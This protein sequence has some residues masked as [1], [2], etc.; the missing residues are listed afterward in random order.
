MPWRK[1]LLIFGLTLSGCQH[2]PAVKRD[3]IHVVP[4]VIYHEGENLI[5]YTSSDHQILMLELNDK[6]LT[7]LEAG[8]D[9]RA[10]KS[11]EEDKP[12]GFFLTNY[13]IIEPF[14]SVQN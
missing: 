10:R 4:V 6:I 14:M 8:A 11:N 13:K 12:D 9:I 5:C 3:P 1:R 7:L 2:S